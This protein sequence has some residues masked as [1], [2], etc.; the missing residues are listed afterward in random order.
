VTF[1]G[2]GGRKHENKSEGNDMVLKGTDPYTFNPERR[3][4][5]TSVN[6]PRWMILWK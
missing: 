3:F 6:A 1:I 2:V 5:E 4:N